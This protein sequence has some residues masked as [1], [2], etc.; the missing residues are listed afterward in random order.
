M[1]NYSNSYSDF[2]D[3]SK[4]AARWSKEDRMRIQRKA[5]HREAHRQGLKL[6]S[7]EERDADKNLPQQ[8]LSQ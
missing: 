4:H 1:R 6:A 5:E 2:S 3:D 8:P 7:L